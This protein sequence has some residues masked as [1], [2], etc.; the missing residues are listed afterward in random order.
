MEQ[1]NFQEILKKGGIGVLPTDTLY[2]LVGSAFLPEAVERIYEA[3]RRDK[4]KPLIVLLSNTQDL[5]WFG[6]DVSSFWKEHEKRLAEIWPGKVSVLFPCNDEVFSYL[7]RETKEIAFRLPDVEFLRGLLA[8]TGPLVA[9]SANPEGLPPAKNIAE[10]KEY[11]GDR[12][13]FYEDGGEMVSDPS[14]LIRFEGGEVKVLREGAV[15]F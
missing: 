8:G 9:P 15:K 3:K 12:V 1:D 13:D 2:G 10:A 11:F 5:E 4:S 7:H 6:A 14:T